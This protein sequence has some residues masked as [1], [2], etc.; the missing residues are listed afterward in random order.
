MP[1][2]VYVF[3]QA[4]PLSR[5]TSTAAKAKNEKMRAFHLFVNDR[6]V[7]FI[8]LEHAIDTVFSEQ[9]I[10]CPFMHVSIHVGCSNR[11]SSTF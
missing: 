10:Y 1:L 7:T 8:K 2:F 4:R 6:L 9:G 5:S 11:F 3:F